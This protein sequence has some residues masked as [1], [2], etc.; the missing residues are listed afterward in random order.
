MRA[1]RFPQANKL[2]GPPPDQRDECVALSICIDKNYQ[3]SQWVPSEEDIERINAGGPIWLFV[4][5]KEHPPVWVQT[6]SPF[7]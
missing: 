7:E 1:R 6:E 2:L 5:S 3:I 4:I